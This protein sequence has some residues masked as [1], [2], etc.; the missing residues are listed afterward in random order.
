[1][2][3]A[4]R[5]VLVKERG[6][7][8]FLP[9]SLVYCLYVLENEVVSM[10]KADHYLVDDIH[11]ILDNGYKDVNPRPKYEDGKPAY[12]ISVN[13]VMRKYDLSLGQFPISTLRRQPWKTGIRELFTIYLKPTNVISEME[14]MKV[15][16]WSPWDI[17]DG[18][19]GQRDGQAL[20]PS[21]QPHRRY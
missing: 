16:W 13:H 20:R 21:Q 5:E 11:N 2:D 8:V 10:T 18:T 9:G 19:I 7:P 4:Q 6:N 15:T 1:M 3:R 12:T 17:G 14:E